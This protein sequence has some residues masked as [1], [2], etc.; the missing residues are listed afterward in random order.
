MAGMPGEPAID[1]AGI[2]KRFGR[3]TALDGIDFRVA[4]ASVFG[5]LGPNGAGKTTLVRILTTLLRPDAGRA[6][7]L[8]HDIVRNGGEVRR[9]IG[10]AGQN[11]AVDVNLTGRENL[12]LIGRLCQLPRATFRRRADELLERFAL[13]E[14]RARPVREYSGG[15]RKRLD[16]AAALM[17]RPPVLF[18]DEPTTGLDLTSRNV[19]WTLIRDLVDEGAT[20]VL[21]TQYLE[22][23]DR[24]ADRIAVLDRGRLIA[25]DTPVA[26][27]AALGATVIEVETD[28]EAQAA[29]TVELLSRTPGWHAAQEGVLVRASANDGARLLLDTV[30]VLDSQAI[31]PRGLRVHAPTL[32]DAFLRLTGSAPETAEQRDAGQDAAGQVA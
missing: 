17:S 13:T 2:T 1:V 31:S 25:E 6:A 30:H 29:R 21:T 12:R 8:G 16:V 3:L 19:L 15:M 26:L 27:K 10:L 5:L 14:A 23:A 32:D 20:V 28:D 9:L 24:L 4:P 18:L 11:A 7:V 22:E